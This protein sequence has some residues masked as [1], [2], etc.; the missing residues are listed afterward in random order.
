MPWGTVHTPRRTPR[1]F[2]PLIFTPLFRVK[3]EAAVFLIYVEH[4]KRQL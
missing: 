2:S 3:I 4:E 1:F